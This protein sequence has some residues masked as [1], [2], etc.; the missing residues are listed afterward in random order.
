[1]TLIT[2]TE[3]AAVPTPLPSGVQDWR[4]CEGAA[5]G[6]AERSVNLVRLRDQPV[7]QLQAPGCRSV[8]HQ[9]FTPFL[10]SLFFLVPPPF[11]NYATPEIRKITAL[12]SMAWDL[13]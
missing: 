5:G 9:S 13:S 8:Q 7:R 3:Q 6:R 1:M 4:G 12:D 11:L 2:N 10:L